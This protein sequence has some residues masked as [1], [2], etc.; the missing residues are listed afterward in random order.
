M[1]R[2]GWLVLLFAGFA[3]A[4][5]GNGTKQDMMTKADGLKTSAEL[6]KVFGKPAEFGGSTFLGQTAEQWTYKASD[7]KVQFYVVNGKVL[8]RVTE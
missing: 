7:G 2:L 6:E 5:C 1:R 4:G 3:L 8:G